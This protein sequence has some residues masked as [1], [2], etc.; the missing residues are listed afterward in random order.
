MFYCI[1]ALNNV[2]YKKIKKL[3][4]I[5]FII[6]IKFQN[7]GGQAILISKKILP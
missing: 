4:N 5:I 6:Y 7:F 1:L 3:F 2:F